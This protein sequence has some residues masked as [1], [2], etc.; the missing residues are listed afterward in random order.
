MRVPSHDVNDA[1]PP[2][3][4][5]SPC[6]SWAFFSSVYF[7]NQIVRLLGRQEI[8]QLPPP[9]SG[10]NIPICHGLQ[11]KQAKADEC[12]KR[13]TVPKYRSK[14]NLGKIL[15]GFQ[16][17]AAQ[18]DQ[19]RSLTHPRLLAPFEDYFVMPWIGF[20]RHYPKNSSFSGYQA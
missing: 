2:V 14:L 3:I 12:F 15:K 20:I 8:D 1:S 9:V 7:D 19:A 17:G 18:S 5:K 11:P 6:K 13:R 4:D 10:S 16:I